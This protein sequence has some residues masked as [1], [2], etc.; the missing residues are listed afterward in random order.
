MTIVRFIK[1][2]KKKRLVTAVPNGNTSLS[3]TT[4]DG[5][6]KTTRWSWLLTRFTQNF[7]RRHGKGPADVNVALDLPRVLQD[8][9][10]TVAKFRVGKVVFGQ[11]LDPARL[12]ALAFCIFNMAASGIY[13]DHN[14]LTC[15]IIEVVFWNKEKHAWNKTRGKIRCT[16]PNRMIH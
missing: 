10:E 11:I 14:R 13:V 9:L 2:H 6:H 1:P 7:P 16:S 5:P 3:G 15:E 12:K 4:E 8:A